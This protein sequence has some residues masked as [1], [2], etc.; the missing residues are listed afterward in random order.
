MAELLRDPTRRNEALNELLR[1]TAAH[2]RSYVLEDG[3]EVLDALTRVF[4]DTLG[5]P[6]NK[7]FYSTGDTDHSRSSS[8]SSLSSAALN[9]SAKTIWTTHATAQSKE[10]AEFC[11]QQL[12]NG[13]MDSTELKL[14]EAVMVILRNLSFVATNHRMLAYSPNVL[15]VLVGSLYETTTP[16]VGANDEK[17][18]DSS[19][20]SVIAVHGVHALVNLASYL[21]VTGQKL[22]CDKLFLVNGGA[23][24]SAQQPSSEETPL[25]PNASTFGQVADGRFGFGGLW[26]AKRLDTKEDMVSDVPR[27][28]VLALTKPYLL[29]VWAIFPALNKIFSDPTSPRLLVM[30][31]EDLLQEFMAQAKMVP[32]APMQD[33]AVEEEEKEDENPDDTKETILRGDPT[34]PFSNARSIM[35]NIPES[36]LRRL[37]E[38]LYIPRLG[39][40]SL[41]YVDPRICI[42]TRVNTLR[43]LLGYDAT[44]D[45]DVRDRA[46][47]ILVPLL[48]LDSPRM[49]KRLGGTGTGRKRRIN[50]HLFDAVLPILTTQAGRTEAPTLAL[51]LFKELSKSPANAMAWMYLQQRLI[52]LASKDPKIAHV[53]FNFLQP[54]HSESTNVSEGHTIHPQGE[55]HGVGEAKTL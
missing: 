30:L 18:F 27:D 10:W 33:E 55:A 49:A 7:D 25:V 51:Q 54:S 38:L 37:V 31:A 22:L 44:V 3:D 45:T 21:D 14:L 40:D 26:L 4:F 1:V 53:V 46:L 24:T 11:T 48:E 39:Y 32:M 19:T 50:P 2:E 29:S 5:W 36:I 34:K 17:A 16:N 15:A 9:V 52:V 8:S 41:D 23:S 12:S 42:V 13:T 28:I 6:L 47:D 35:V 43:M 20:T